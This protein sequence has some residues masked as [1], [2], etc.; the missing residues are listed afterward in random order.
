[1]MTTRHATVWLDHQEA[2]IFH[3]NPD[4][5]E[6][7]LLHVAH[8]LHR[9]HKTG[10]HA[11]LHRSAAEAHPF[12]EEIASHLADA[13][14]ILV[15]G[16]GTAK[17]ELVKLVEERHPDLAKRIVGVEASDHPTDAQIV[18]HARKHFLATTGAHPARASGT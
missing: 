4:D 10:G 1:M 17:L 15:V 3:I 11:E 18:A 16:P 7:S 13:E 2:K 5:V 9:A 14:Q 6:R 8:H 12:F